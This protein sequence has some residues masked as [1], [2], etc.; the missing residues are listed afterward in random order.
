LNNPLMASLLKH[1]YAHGICISVT[2]RPTPQKAGFIRKISRTV[3]ETSK[4][5][6]T[7]PEYLEIR[8]GKR[9]WET[10]RAPHTFLITTP[11]DPFSSGSDHP[12]LPS[13]P[14]GW[15]RVLWLSRD[16]RDQTGH[17]KPPTLWHALMRMVMARMKG[18]DPMIFYGICTMACTGESAR[19]IVN[20]V[21]D[22]SKV[23]DTF[24][25]PQSVQ[26]AGE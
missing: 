2:T 18:I 3:S 1:S 10:V 25:A 21:F 19:I 14:S 8:R 17:G 15:C 23:L 22:V 26:L 16:G 6:I 11:V 9:R 5:T 4:A 7:W 20:L 13:R 12:F 24:L